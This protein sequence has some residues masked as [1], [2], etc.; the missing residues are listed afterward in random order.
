[1]DNTDFIP[2]RL[3]AD[4]ISNPSETGKD[5][6][7]PPFMFSRELMDELGI[8]D[9]QTCGIMTGFGEAMKPTINGKC[10]LLVDLSDKQL[11]DGRIYLL[12]IG[13]RVLVR[14][15]KLLLRQIILACD[16]PEYPDIVVE[17]EDLNRLNVIGRVR[18]IGQRV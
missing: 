1:M 3:I 2:A 6:Q 9:H 14:R 17:G 7:Q 8:A 10:E 4:R 15:V 18:Y 12:Q 5:E 11:H 16:N 13:I